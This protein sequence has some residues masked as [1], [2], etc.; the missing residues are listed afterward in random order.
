MSGERAPLPRTLYHYTDSDGLAGILTTGHLLAS[1]VQRNPK[2]VRYGE[3]A[4]LSD[5]EPDTLS[6]AR[7]SRR[8]LGH[9]FSSRRFTHYLE[10][11]VNGW[12]VIEG[13]PGVF[14][15]PGPGPFDLSGRIVRSGEV[16]PAGV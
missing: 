8:F 13:R 10:I 9:P 12:E 3:G 6:P 11:L 15:V 16:A 1:T 14:V 5:I 2:D 7:L 4:Y